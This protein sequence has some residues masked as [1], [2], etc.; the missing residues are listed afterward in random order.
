MYEI[1]L[2]DK[3]DVFSL[4]LE[5]RINIEIKELETTYENIDNLDKKITA[6]LFEMKEKHL[7][8]VKTLESLL[9]Q[10]AQNKGVKLDLED[11]EPLTEQNRFMA[12]PKPEVLKKITEK[13]RAA[14]RKIAQT[15]HPDKTNNKELVN[16]FLAAKQMLKKGM[17]DELVKLLAEVTRFKNVLSVKTLLDKFLKEKLQKVRQELRH[18]KDKLNVFQESDLAKAVL[19]A[20]QGD[21]TELKSYYVELVNAKIAKARQNLYESR[22]KSFTASYSIF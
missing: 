16:F 11:F 5:E 21:D 15:C 22:A 2:A 17:N 7:E 8:L 1:A 13:G 12:E 20:E 19:K 14:Y 6:A 9:S 4:C 3:P 18:A 10:V